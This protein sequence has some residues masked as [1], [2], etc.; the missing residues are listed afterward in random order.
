M[1][2]ILAISFL[3]L[4]CSCRQN[5]PNQSAEGGLKHVDISVAEALAMLSKN[6]AI[7]L[8]VRTPGEIAN[9]KISGALDY[10]F[11]DK[12]FGKNILA[13]EKT[14][15]YIVYCKS[16]GRSAKAA[17]LMTDAGFTDVYNMLGGFSAWQPQD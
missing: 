15:P 8:D 12:E 5:S 2:F 16:G 10:N 4:L 1:R 14:K 9:G 13:L 3:L 17:K 7:A 6:Q 11:R